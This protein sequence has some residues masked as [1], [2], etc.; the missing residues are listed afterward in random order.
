ML[1]VRPAVLL[2]LVMTLL[3]AGTPV[4]RAITPAEL[5]VGAPA[6]RAAAGNRIQWQGQD[7]FL[8]GANVPWL[9]WGRDFGGGA[10]DGVSAPDNKATL[11]NSFANAKANGANV[12][13]WWTFAGDPW[14]IKRD[15]S[16]APVAL[17][18]AVYQDF[19]AAMEL[20]EANDVY[21]VF[22]LFSGS[23][24]IP[25][26]WVEDPGQ[27]ARLVQVLTPL[28]QR[29]ADNPRV[30]SWD[31]FNEPEGDIWKTKVSEQGFRATV[32]AFTDAIHANSRALV[33]VGLTMLDG[34]PMVTGLGL[35]YYQ[36][37]WY[38]YMDSGDWCVPC[39]DYSATRLRWN[40]DA[41]VVIGEIFV[42]PGLD[43]PHL[44]L[45]DLYTK[46]YAGAWTWSMRIIP[47][48]IGDTMDT[49]WDAMRVFS[50]RHPDLGPRVTPALSYVD[51]PESVQPVQIGFH[52][53]ASPASSRVSPG[54]RVPIDVK[55]TSTASTRVLIDLEI[56][57]AKGDK[58]HQQY[59]D[60]ETFGPG[61]T[62]AFTSN[63]TVPGDLPPGEYAIKVGVFT[64]GWGKTLDWNDSANKITVVR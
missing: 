28:F 7:W 22:V 40:L 37:H 41:P 24:A 59:W 29:Y 43:N 56:Y 23:A 8:A 39:K 1:M 63:W 26:S 15:A 61:A 21:Y 34:L 27:R 44:R 19:D 14:Q 4:A 48:H 55:V 38:D 57:N 5:G 52:S 33:T 16:G 35:D 46:G 11:M 32:K 62:K 36:A 31:I 13:R 6:T 50:G 53:E 51:V 2:M 47:S 12:L 25:T 18:E 3:V 20:A 42:G 17:D 30:M 45:E 64:A 49:D 10:K 58:I 9:T 60:N 54:T